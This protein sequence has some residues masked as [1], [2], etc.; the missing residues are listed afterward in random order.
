MSQ[1]SVRLARR[2]QVFAYWLTLR[3]PALGLRFAAI[4]G[5]IAAQRANSAHA[6]TAE[7]VEELFGTL[8]PG[9]IQRIRREIAS[10]EFRDEALRHLLGHRGLDPIFV[11]VKTVRAE[12]FRQLWSAGTPIVVVGWHQ[13]P[14]RAASLA[15]R[16]L[17]I[18][19][20][21]A[22]RS[23][24]REPDRDGDIVRYAHLNGTADDARF[25][26]RAH[27]ALL[28]GSVVG[29]HIDWLRDT[30]EEAHILGRSVRV[31]RGAVVLARITGARLVPVTRRFLGSTGYVEVTLHAPIADADL[32]PAA[33][34][35]FEHALLER[36]VA[37]FEASI[38]S[39]PGSLRLEQMMW[40][41]EAPPADGC[42]SETARRAVEG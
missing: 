9:R 37:W 5:R 7:N 20:L 19:T 21:F 22:I 42:A 2:I 31:G 24:N 41:L 27:R 25:L 33:G 26:K 11:L 30:G 17:G 14:A 4:L 10:Q 28:D 39:D 13:G 15:L 35:A 38:R 16:K 12:S 1:I 36:A 18:P 23:A 34:P 3:R 8:E 6:P 29:L 32:D 40:L